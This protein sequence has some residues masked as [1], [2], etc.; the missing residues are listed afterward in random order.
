MRK[1]F[2]NLSLFFADFPSCIQLYIEP[3]QTN[4]SLIFSI[5]LVK[6]TCLWSIGGYFN[7][8]FGNI[9]ITTTAVAYRER[10]VLG[11]WLTHHKNRC[12]NTKYNKDF[13]K[14]EKTFQD[15]SKSY[16]EETAS[17]RTAIL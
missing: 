7:E 10:K 17:T 11:D 14:L 5:L 16:L 6:T 15:W 4:D 2:I 12:K 3:Q 13:Y 8:V 1:D 9:L